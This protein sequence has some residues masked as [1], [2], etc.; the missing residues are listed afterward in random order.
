MNSVLLRFMLF[1]MGVVHINQE[2]L[3]TLFMVH[4]Y[5]LLQDESVAAAGKLSTNAI[6]VINWMHFLH[7]SF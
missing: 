2:K 6:V 3:K 1:V 4:F 7:L 5:F